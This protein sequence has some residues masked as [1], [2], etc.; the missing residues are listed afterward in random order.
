[1]FLTNC[2]LLRR[3]VDVG[4]YSTGKMVVLLLMPSM[5]ER[6]WKSRQSHIDGWDE[7]LFEHHLPREL[8]PSDGA[9]VAVHSTIEQ[10]RFAT[11]CSPREKSPGN[12]G[13]VHCS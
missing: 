7:S 9:L 13:A 2:E 6:L 5:I 11:T 3:E 10:V 8:C 12:G 4:S 1:M